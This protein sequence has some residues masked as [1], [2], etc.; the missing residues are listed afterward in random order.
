MIYLYPAN[1]M[2]NLLALL[3]KIQQI[4]PLPVL[5]E[6]V[7][8]VHNA[9]MQHWLN[10]SLAEKRGI[11][12]NFKYALP[13]QYL[14]QLLRSL[15]NGEQVPKQSPYSREVLT[16]RLDELLASEK[17]TNDPCFDSVNNYWQQENEQL[18]QAQ[19]KRFQL[20]TQLADLFEQYLIFR[21]NWLNNWQQGKFTTSF[22]D[23]NDNQNKEKQIN[24]SLTIWQAKLWQ[25]LTEDIAYNPQEIVDSAI[26]NIA[27][28]KHLLPVRLSFF[29]VNSLA[30]IWLEFISALSEHIEVHFFH[31]NPCFDYWGDLLT[32]KQAIKIQQ[33]W[34]DGALTVDQQLSDLI[35]NPLLA[36]LGQQG[37]EFLALLQQYSSINIETFEKTGVEPQLNNNAPLHNISVLEQVQ[38]DILSLTDARTDSQ[39]R[40]DNS[41]TITSCHSALREVQ[42]LHDWLLHQFNQDSSL[43]PKDV[44]VMCPQVENY[45][46]FID[47]VFSRGWQQE[48]Q[49]T[50]QTPQLPCSIADRISKDSEP[51]VAAFIELLQLPDSRFQV[52]K[53]IGLLR[54]PAMQAK[55]CINLDE[56]TKI[57]YWL[58]QACIHWGLNAEHKQALLDVEL[59][60]NKFT[61]EQGLSR[62]LL[63]F[64][65]GDENTIF[66]EQLLLATVEGGDA[67]L[68]GKLMQIIEQLQFFAQHLSSDKNSSSWLSFLHNLLDELF[69]CDDELAFDIINNAL[70]SL[71][72]FCEEANYYHKISLSVVRDFLQN[73][74]SEP[75]PGRQFL[76][77]QVTFCSML[78]MRSIPFK[79][80][81]VLGLN[82][83]KFPRQRQ[84]LGFDLMAITPSKIG[85]RSR[86]G[87]DRYLF[88]EAIICA[89][90]A[91]YLSYQG[92]NIR[93]NN[94]LQPSLVLKELMEYLDLGYGWSLLN[95]NES[96]QNESNKENIDEKAIAQLSIKEQQRIQQSRIQQLPMQPF[97]LRNYTLNIQKNEKKSEYFSPNVQSSI[98][99]S[100]DINWLRFAQAEQLGIA[101]N[102]NA[103]NLVL[104]DQRYSEKNIA[105]QTNT[106]EISLMQL[107]TFFEHPA[108]YFAK[109]HLN[110]HFEQ[111]QT[112]LNDTEPFKSEPLVSYQLKQQLLFEK[113]LSENQQDNSNQSLRRTSKE[114]INIALEEAELSGRFPDSPLT[115]QEFEKWQI[116]SELLASAIRVEVNDEVELISV[117]LP[118]EVSG[119]KIN[120]SAQL[121]ISAQQCVCYR[122]S[123]AKAKDL[124]ILYLY[125]LFCVVFQDQQELTNTSPVNQVK[126]STGWY[127][128]TKN[129]Q[130]IKKSFTD[131]VDALAQLNHFLAVFLQGQQQALLLNSSIGERYFNT[132]NFEQ[133]EFE[134][135][136]QDP[137]SF[138]TLGD[139]PYMQFFWPSC[140][141]LV[142]H[143]QYIEQLYQG[144]YQAL[145]SDKITACSGSTL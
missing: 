71:V 126:Q 80:I 134:K 8:I 66:Q 103:Y 31:L 13:S 81:A 35:G 67:L 115:A 12:M 10:L 58:E 87:D 114:S 119:Q 41:I 77:G 97:S 57:S 74:F 53:L 9:G 124:M 63:G 28:N 69:I 83:G 1:K 127:F 132:R 6:E 139:D 21:P 2:E 98:F 110:L 78:P 34:L 116:D 27:E 68:L 141:Q 117:V 40:I 38:N 104:A 3:D 59:T 33:K 65:Y 106:L 112:Q 109:H 4:S 82:D 125:R 26:K 123:S 32:A 11:S 52:S 143:Q 24:D 46:P 102:N 136:W 137:N 19:L 120:L 96:K 56:I 64:A 20:A 61:W 99:G 60:N 15:A 105:Q 100:F 39:S 121:P 113:L 101:Q 140:P 122:S 84:P 75:D 17:V 44:L 118:L 145:H 135:L 50:I 91:L 5:S 18:K 111:Y 144:L 92:R 7:I 30:P 54:L 142:D 51:L 88:L 70:N 90:S 48:Q 93:N 42:G 85:D 73:H 95:K 138:K 62:L 86:R 129:Q 133:N 107:V 76:V 14:W 108:K 43:T 89:R 128:D 79:V 23:Q 25:F 37:R 29:G 47:A 45:A 16:W 72:D 49:G 55:F 36:N 130:V 94:E 22:R 131:V